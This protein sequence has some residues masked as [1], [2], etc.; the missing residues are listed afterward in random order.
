MQG[1]EYFISFVEKINKRVGETAAYILPVFMC[2]MVYEVAMRYFF[3]SPTMWVHETCGYLFAF[4]I[5]FTGGWILLLKGH[6]SVDIAYE[7][8]SR[9]MKL[10]ADLIVSIAGFMLFLV[11][12]WFGWKYAWHAIITNQH[13]HTVFAPPMWP[14]KIMLPAASLLFLIQIAADI[15]RSLLDL[16]RKE[17]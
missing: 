17:M 14:V 2:L 10:I 16:K 1:I 8:F 9:K 4:Y 3:Q 15:A 6:V 7:R 12:L 11:L 5:A 13:S